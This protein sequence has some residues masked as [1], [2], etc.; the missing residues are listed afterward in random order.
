MD[1]LNKYL[2]RQKYVVRRSEGS[3]YRNFLLYVEEIYQVTV[4]YPIKYLFD[5][6]LKY[7]EY[8]KSYKKKDIDNKNLK[9]F[10]NIIKEQH[11]INNEQQKCFCCYCRQDDMVFP[12]FSHFNYKK[13]KFKCNKKEQEEDI[14]LTLSCLK[15]KDKIFHSFFIQQ[16]YNFFMLNVTLQQ[17]EMINYYYYYYYKL[18]N[19]KNEYTYDIP[20]FLLFAEVFNVK[21][22]FNVQK[23]YRN[24]DIEGN[25][26]FVDSNIF[27]DRIILEDSFKD[28]DILKNSVIVKSHH[29]DEHGLTC[30]K[31]IGYPI[32][33]NRGKGLCRLKRNECFHKQV[34][35]FLNLEKKLSSKNNMSYNYS[36]FMIRKLHMDEYNEIDEG[37][38]KTNEYIYNIN[39]LNKINEIIDDYKYNNTDRY[40]YDIKIDNNENLL[41]YIK[42][43]Y[44]IGLQKERHHFIDIKSHNE[45]ILNISY[46]E[47]GIGESVSFVHILSNCYNYNNEKKNISCSIYI[48]IWNEE[49]I[50][51]EINV[52]IKCKQRIVND[53]TQLNKKLFLCKKCE[54]TILIKF[55]PIYNMLLASCHVLITKEERNLDIKNIYEDPNIRGANYKEQ[56]FLFVKDEENVEASHNYK[57]KKGKYKTYDYD[58]DMVNMDQ[59]VQNKEY[60][61][62][63]KIYNNNNNNNNDNIYHKNVY[64]IKEVPLKFDEQFYRPNDHNIML[65]YNTMNF[66][67][68]VE[69]YILRYKRKFFFFI[70]KSGNIV[71]IILFL[72]LVI[73]LC[74][75]IIPSLPFC[76]YFFIKLKWFHKLKTIRLLI[77]WKVQ[78][79]FTFFKKIPR[80]VWRF[81][82]KIAKKCKRVLFKIFI[83]YKKDQELIDQ[84]YKEKLQRKRKKERKKKQ[85]RKKYQLQKK[86]KE[87]LRKKRYKK[88][89]E[90]EKIFQKE[91]KKELMHKRNNKIKHEN[92]HEENYYINNKNDHTYGHKSKTQKHYKKYHDKYEDK[93]HHKYHKKEPK[94]KN[95]YNHLNNPHN[96]SY[97]DLEKNQS[98]TS[99]TNSSQEYYEK[100][101]YENTLSS[102]EHINI[103]NTH[104]KSKLNTFN[105]KNTY[106]NQYIKKE[107]YDKDNIYSDFYAIKN[108]DQQSI[109]QEKKKNR[110]SISNISKIYKN[111][112]TIQLSNKDS[113]T[114]RKDLLP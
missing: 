69:D 8:F 111:N 67:E 3:P 57:Y 62:I 25:Y 44:Y 53:I 79:T 10:C 30:N 83:K 27:K 105:N 51:K 64:I 49:D 39:K 96:P 1:R 54:E 92:K 6:P 77:L 46:D 108:N 61:K 12:L 90:N 42:N 88:L 55:E 103:K 87:I 5:I 33:W 28:G 85:I 74:I 93:Y 113:K 71:K 65:L 35:T 78:D 19:S 18:Y 48:S 104:H 4:V 95:I 50:E 38:E 59:R 40:K 26:L 72:F 24:D 94:Q 60:H 11:E 45:E 2:S 14:V 75:F 110:R 82:K 13:A 43:N 41:E 89:I 16:N 81:I 15:K 107:P 91:M 23:N 68:N 34:S 47:E 29:V 36:F 106:D 37:F 109:L 73:I 70:N 21:I 100:K 63:D 58:D 32:Y 76:T 114:S 101:K 84:E 86:E 22:K 112:D 97:N 56:H 17:F 7:Y 9:Q 102:A 80:K 20:A 99:N 31:I 98:L 52:F 66:V